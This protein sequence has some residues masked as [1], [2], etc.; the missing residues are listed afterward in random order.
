MTANP[1][2]FIFDDKTSEAL[3]QLKKDL[4]LPSKSAV[5][6]KAIALLMLANQTA[7]KSPSHSVT[8]GE[9]DDR[10]TVMLTG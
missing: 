4:G 2:S 6:R 8:I 1:T 5:L 3:D 7:A 9:G 10:H